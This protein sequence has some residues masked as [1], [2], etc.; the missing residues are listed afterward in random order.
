V[1]AAETRVTISEADEKL[2]QKFLQRI[3]EDK[4]KD[5]EAKKVLES[6]MEKMDNTG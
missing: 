2:K 1:S 3:K 6:R 4:E 5:A